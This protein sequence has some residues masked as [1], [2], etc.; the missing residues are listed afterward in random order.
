M[1]VYFYWGE[2]DFAIAQAVKTLRQQ[3]VDPNWESF[4]YEKIS[5]EQPDGMQR[6]LNQMMTPPFGAGK[7]LVWLSETTLGQRC[8]EALLAELEQTLPK[9]PETSVLLLTSASKPDGRLKS[10]KLLQKYGEVREFSLLPPWK[11]ADLLK[12]VQQTAQAVGV[13]LT[14][15][16]A[17]QLAIAVGGNTRQLHS[18]LEKL[19]LYCTGQ[20]QAVDEATVAQLVTT[21]SKSAIQLAQAICQGKT[22]IALDLAADLQRQNEPAL[23][24]TRSL[25]TSFRTWLWVKLLLETGE[26][27]E[28]AIAAAAELS[29]PKRL[30]F[31]KQEVSQVS[32]AGLLQ[33]LPILLELDASLKRGADELITLQ[34]KIVELCEVCRPL[35]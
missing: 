18:E 1:A 12:Q 29:N 4:N 27:D 25:V 35:R 19:R 33:S 6:A 11:T 31:L 16:A 30:Y 28:Q 34:T 9:L 14:P 23:V 15:A 2:D 13:N 7:R 26:R 20:K 24:I 21:T 8:S 10:T 5:P 17:E 32:L 3:T 22:A